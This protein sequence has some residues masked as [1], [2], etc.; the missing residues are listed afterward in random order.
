M[1]KKFILLV[2]SALAC[3][4]PFQKA[5]AQP[6]VDGGTSVKVIKSSPVVTNFIGWAYDET[7]EK[8]CGYYNAL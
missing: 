2:I 6:R 5:V 4:F 1:Q 7:T 8:W 3:L